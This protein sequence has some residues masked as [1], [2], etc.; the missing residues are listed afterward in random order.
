MSNF[1]WPNPRRIIVILTIAVAAAAL[2][3]GGYFIWDKGTQV[4]RAELQPIVQQEAIPFDNQQI[5]AELIDTL[6]ANKV[7]LLGENHFLREH[8]EFE[9]ALLPELHARGFRQYLFEWTQAADWLLA[10]FVNDGGLEPGWTPPHDI[11]GAALT[12]IRDFNRTLP[13]EERIQVHGIDVH[14]A[15]YGGAA[16]WVVI[17]DA[18]LRHLPDPGPLTAVLQGDH[19]TAESHQAL[20]AA[21]QAE[22]ADGRSALTAAW[23]EDVYDTIVEMVEVELASLQVRAL[24]GS[25]YDQS[26]RLREEAIQG[27]SERRIGEIPGG[28]L[29]N[30]GATHAQKK[31]LWGTE[32]V[33]WLGDYLA[34]QSPA[35]EGAVFVLWVTPANIK[36][37]PDSGTPDFDLSAS[38]PNELLRV[39]HE[40][41]PD[42]T[43]FLPLDDPL[44]SSSRIPINVSGEIF[45]SA[46]AQQF[47][48]VL[49]LPVAHRDFVGD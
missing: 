49:L 22:L 47:D 44:F 34:H 43:I 31:G 20:L 39:I 29:I 5:P 41:W 2:F 46:P 28:T 33:A 45:V 4:S 14:L 24:R 6:A 13:P 42:E 48:G 26:V 8:R 15:D 1:K 11:G 35:A 30:M 38:P 40:T 17:L 18:L 25:D 21:L 36:E 9:A 32:N 10:D 27:L 37:L 7:V 12:A 23:G 19:G 3:F 16:S